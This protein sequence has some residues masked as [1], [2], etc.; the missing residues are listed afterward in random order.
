MSE[1]SALKV[2]PGVET[3]GPLNEEQA[4]LF[5]RRR[6]ARR[7]LPE[8]ID[9]ILAGD[10]TVLAQAITLLESSLPRDRELAEQVI[11]AVLPS[12]GNSIRIGITGV[13][14]VGKSTFIEALG[15]HITEERDGKLAVLAIDPSSSISGGSI[16][17]DKTR[18]AKLGMNPKAFIRPS[19]SRC[20]LGGVAQ[21]TRETVVLCEAAGFNNI[22][23]ETVGVG[24]SETIVATMVDF[25]LLLM[26]PG[27]GDELQGIKR[28]II[29][30]SDLI[31]V[32]KA[33]G[34]N[35]VRAELARREYARALHLFPPHASG[36][37]PRVVTCS[38]VSHDGVDEIWDAVQSYC[39]LTRENGYFD[40]RR[41][42]Q[43]RRWMHELIE[44]SLRDRF[45]A[46]PR[47]RERLPQLE[48]EV[49]EGRMTS[50]RAALELLQTRDQDTR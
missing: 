14:G 24:Q 15:T 3:T 28:G 44:Q 32:N 8:Y 21:R 40:L 22:F 6:R 30:M 31:A 23:I 47:V 43:D 5:Q 45:M 1:E 25:F 35:K 36:W 41:R 27:A 18:M 48:R 7:T 26:L 37:T 10:R 38:A 42:D 20:S 29:E 39:N 2:V 49:A 16:L 33:D 11:E 17:G 19:P 12:S 46:D 9:G 4:R 34:D 50:Y 13:P